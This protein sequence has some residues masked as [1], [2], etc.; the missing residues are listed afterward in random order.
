MHWSIILSTCKAGYILAFPL[1]LPS[2]GHVRSS[3]RRICFPFSAQAVDLLPAHSAKPWKAPRDPCALLLSL[4]LLFYFLTASRWHSQ[5]LGERFVLQPTEALWNR[6]VVFFTTSEEARCLAQALDQHLRPMCPAGIPDHKGG[7][8]PYLVPW[9]GGFR[10]D[11]CP[12]LQQH[13]CFLRSSVWQEIQHYK[14]RCGFF[15]F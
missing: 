10:R 14:T 2:S 6:N 12:P 8:A 3:G 9:Q 4:G 1:E 7:S 13:H 15:L 5:H 11:P